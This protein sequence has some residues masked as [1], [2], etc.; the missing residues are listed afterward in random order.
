[1]NMNGT[2]VPVSAP[3]GFPE[4]FQMF[5]EMFQHF[6]NRLFRVKNLLS[7]AAG[8]LTELPGERRRE[9][10]EVAETDFK[11]HFGNGLVGGK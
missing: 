4:M 11:C 2:K 1:M 6:K 5:P 9:V 10:L 7:E 8:R 3:A